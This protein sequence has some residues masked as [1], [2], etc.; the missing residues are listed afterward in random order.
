MVDRRDGRFPFPK[1]Y[2][3]L[4]RLKANFQPSTKLAVQNH[5]ILWRWGSLPAFVS[6]LARR[7]IVL[8]IRGTLPVHD[9]MTCTPCNVSSV[10]IQFYRQLDPGRVHV[11]DAQP[12][13]R[14]QQ[15]L[16]GQ[17]NGL[18]RDA[19]RTHQRTQA[20]DALHLKQRRTWHREHEVGAPR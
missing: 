18:C 1:A 15:T 10:L 2:T 16:D 14:R 20:F 3:P 13:G 9:S 19:G 5:A 6:G 12:S 11:M 8:R 4:R 7:A 17:T